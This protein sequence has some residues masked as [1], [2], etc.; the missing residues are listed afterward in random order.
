MHFSEFVRWHFDDLTRAYEDAGRN[1]LA[2]I[3]FDAVVLT[4]AAGRVTVIEGW[5]VPAVICGTFCMIG[6][7]VLA[8][9][10]ITPRRVESVNSVELQQ[11]WTAL[12]RGGVETDFRYPDQ[13]LEH[14]LHSQISSTGEAPL[15][16]IR[17][18]ADLRGR[19]LLAAVMFSGV[20]AIA[21]GMS[22][23]VEIW[24]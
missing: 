24:R 16:Q 22:F 15:L 8:L 9:I 23:L 12:A 14:L 21:F 18:A 7:L 1:S 10:A 17:R 2:L 13:G 6:A 5:A 20:G 19:F 11:E 3:G 4:L